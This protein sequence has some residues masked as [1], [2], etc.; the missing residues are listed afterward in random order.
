MAKI[1]MASIKFF[2]QTARYNFCALGLFLAIPGLAQADNEGVPLRGFVDVG[3]AAHSKQAT[4]PKG[5]NVGSLDFYLTPQ[6][7]DNLKALIEIIFETTSDGSIATDL[8]RAQMGYTF[9]DNATLWAG[10]FHAPFG[11]WNTGFHHG[12]EIQTAVLRPRFLDFEDKGG[13]LPV[14]MVGLWGT[15]KLNAGDNFITYDVYAGNGPKISMAEDA[16]IQAPGTLNI[17]TAGDNNHQAMLGINFGYEFSGNLSGLRLALHALRGDVDDDS[18]GLIPGIAAANKTGLGMV[19]GA[20]IYIENDWEVMG[21][22]YRFNNKDKSGSS[23]SH[24]S[25]ADYLQVGKTINNITPF[26]R[27]EKTQLNQSDNY[28]SMQESGQ[29]YNRQA[30]GVKYDLNEKAALK[31]ELLNTRFATGGLRVASSYRSFL[32]QFA[33]RF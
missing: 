24:T 8:E 30:L 31:F 21:E 33:I 25:W 26:L 17:N 3:F 12:A 9:N 10:R 11:Y 28:F 19:G 7:D 23:G 5:F 18:N 14:H 13:I 1:K 4:V 15:G 16:G 32:A 22:Y 2:R 6:F 20:I 29:S 27:V